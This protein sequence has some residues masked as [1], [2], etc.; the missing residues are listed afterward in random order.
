MAFANV[1]KATVEI[2]LSTKGLVVVSWM[3][4]SFLAVTEEL[5][6]I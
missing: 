5:V 2:R 3:N 6:L 4:R 1:L